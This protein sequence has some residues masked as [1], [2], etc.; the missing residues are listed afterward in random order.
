MRT[1]SP[2]AETDDWESFVLVY[3]IF[4]CMVFSLLR[5]STIRRAHSPGVSYDRPEKIYNGLKE[6]WE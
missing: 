3:H 6:T 5:R 2:V 4:S 1:V